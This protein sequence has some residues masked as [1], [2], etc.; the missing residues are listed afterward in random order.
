M[1]R[2]LPSEETG[3]RLP[4]W[5]QLGWR[6]GASYVF[7][8]TLVVVVIGAVGL[9]GAAGL[10]A[11]DSTIEALHAWIRLRTRIVIAGVLLV[12][13]A[14]AS[15]ALVVLQIG[16][17]VRQ[18][19]EA[20]RRA[21]AGDRTARVP[22]L[23]QAELATLAQA[24]ND[25]VATWSA[26]VDSLELQVDE[27]TRALSTAATVSRAASTE[28]DPEVL[29]QRVVTLIQDRFGLYY[30]GLFLVDESERWAVL[31]AGTGTFGEV[32]LRQG[33]RLQVGGQSMIGQC[34]QGNRP[35]VALD[36]GEAAVRFDNPLLPD[37]R[38]EL[39]LPVRS[40]GGVIGAMTIQST[41]PAAFDRSYVD[42]LQ[43]MADQVGV[44][45]DNAR[46]FAEA[47]FTL[48]ELEATQRRYLGERWSGYV[49]QR[50]A[51]GYTLTRGRIA[52][53]GD[54]V[55]PEAS[56]AIELQQSLVFSPAPARDGE[57]S[58]VAEGTPG[59]GASLDVRAEQER[60][61][62]VTPITVGG[63]PIG[64]LG[65]RGGEEREW[66]AADV[67]LVR[68]VGAQFA[69]AAENLRLIEQMERG[70]A[71]ERMSR[72][73]TEQIRAAVSVEDAVRRTLDALAQT[74][75]VDDL[76]VHVGAEDVVRSRLPAQGDGDE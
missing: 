29:V 36:V 30:V 15:G 57:Q 65:V 17:P 63:Q 3:S 21:A 6:L 44:A 27:R 53:L 24:F 47:Q 59:N 32:M 69:E 46:L 18:L 35:I 67:E 56:Q 31:R 58:G 43:S 39:A 71:T 54:R 72:R 62:L 12:A 41:S 26:L 2:E 38:S 50:H 28:L 49:S 22:A 55:L 16:R 70:Q 73:V 11:E 23:G 14:A 66:S 51:Q 1:S 64:A 19:A 40:R 68:A 20:A 37:T 52:P 45:I 13:A 48:R 61:V 5:R 34:I 33:H 9:A 4:P 60:S 75:G 25:M 10:V 8:V 7:L 42:I 76:V 74:L